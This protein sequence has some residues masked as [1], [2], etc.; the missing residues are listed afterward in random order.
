MAAVLARLAGWHLLGEQ[1]LVA[2]G[3][4]SNPQFGLAE[5]CFPVCPQTGRFGCLGF[6]E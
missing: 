1:L 3:T 5:S 4:I 6:Q 2:A